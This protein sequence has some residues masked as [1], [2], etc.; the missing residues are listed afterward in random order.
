MTILSALPADPE[1]WRAATECGDDVSVEYWRR[2]PLRYFNAE[3]LS[4]AVAGLLAA[5]RPYAAADLAAFEGQMD[6]EA[7]TGEL[8]ATVLDQAVETPTEHDL[9]S[10]QFGSSAGFLLD[11]MVESRC[12]PG[13]V[14]RLEWLLIPA[15]SWHR[16]A[17]MPCINSLRGSR[18]LRG[19]AV[20]GLPG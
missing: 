11:V 2:I 12:D 10:S 18:V 1:T 4:D 7:V 16:E 3:H 9:P 17:L 6:R 8:A 19:N 20:A 5:G 13:R 15:L 14:A